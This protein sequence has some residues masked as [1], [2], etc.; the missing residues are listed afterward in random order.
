MPPAPRVKEIIFGGRR[1]IA[2]GDLQ[3]D[4][5]SPF[6]AFSR[7]DRPAGAS[8]APTGNDRR[9]PR[10]FRSAGSVSPDARREGRRHTGRAMYQSAFG[11]T[12]PPFQ[13]TADPHFYFA[14]GKRREAL[15]RLRDWSAAGRD[16]VVV[17]G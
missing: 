4:T 15:D 10:A 12:A 13:L 16:V 1:N 14:S 17:T 11:I 6:W 2:I 7:F 3:K 5:F 9:W 8:G